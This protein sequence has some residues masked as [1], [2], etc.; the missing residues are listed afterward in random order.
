MFFSFRDR[1]QITD[2]TVVFV[3][4]RESSPA[5][6]PTDGSEVHLHFFMCSLTCVGSDGHPV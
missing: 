4:V 2:F 1:S 3:E 6:G 5:L